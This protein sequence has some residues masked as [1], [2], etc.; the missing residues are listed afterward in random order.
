MTKGIH[1]VATIG[2]FDGVHKGHLIV[3]D[4]VLS[5]AHE[6]ALSPAVFAFAG[7]PLEIIDPARVPPKLMTFDEQCQKFKSLGIETFPIHFTPQL[8]EISSADYM[9]FLHDDHNVEVLV[10]GYDNKFGHDRNS[11]F[12]DYRLQASK[13]GIEVIKADEMPMV[14]STIIRRLISDGRIAE[15]NEKLGYLYPL[16]G[17]VEHGKEL[18]RTI[19]FPTANLHPTDHQKLIPQNGVYAA[20]AITPDGMR[21]KAMINIGHRPTIRDGRTHQSI[22]ANIFD[23]DDNLYNQ[24]ITLE[25]V[26]FMR[27]EVRMNS[28]EELTQRLIDDRKRALQILSSPLFNHQ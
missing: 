25:F 24:T 10:I 26:E 6:R 11:S 5:I 20:F 3:L 14:S 17:I 23:F 22:E 18:G 7:H 28:I 13:I 9:K 15:A 4:Q 12:D 16:T 21:R 19:G 1:R 2:T 27:T 8:R